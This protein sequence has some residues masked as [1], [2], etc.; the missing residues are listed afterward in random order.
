MINLI[1][2]A[3]TFVAAFCFLMSLFMMLQGNEILEREILNAIFLLFF[4]AFLLFTFDMPF[5]NRAWYS[6]L[7]SAIMSVYIYRVF[8]VTFIASYREVQAEQESDDE[9]ND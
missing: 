7:Y 3:L 6:H 5:E 2:P 9:T 4:C 8:F 1:Y